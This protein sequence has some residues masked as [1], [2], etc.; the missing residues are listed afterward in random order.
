MINYNIQIACVSVRKMMGN[1][2]KMQSLHFFGGK[3]DCNCIQYIG[4]KKYIYISES[5]TIWTSYVSI[6][7]NDYIMYWCKT[8]CTMM[9]VKYFVLRNI[10]FKLAGAC[11]A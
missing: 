6:C 1:N 2:H 8:D 7:T 4:M 3:R 5:I 10:V 9:I 11:E